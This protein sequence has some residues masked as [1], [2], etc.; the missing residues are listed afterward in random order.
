MLLPVE[1]RQFSYLATESQDYPCT[2]RDEYRSCAAMT[3]EILKQ[4]HQP[5]GGEV[6]SR[7]FNDGGGVSDPIGLY[8]P[9][10]KSHMA[11][12]FPTAESLKQLRSAP[13]RISVDGAD[14]R[15]CHATV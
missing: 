8:Y 10:D 9:E 11:V 14:M 5:K 3:T 7:P 15:A 13:L 6:V 4:L 12:V 2:I 1:Q